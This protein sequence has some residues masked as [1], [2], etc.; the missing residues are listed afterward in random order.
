MYVCICRA[1]TEEDIRATL[2]DGA[3]SMRELRQRLG[4]C[5][6]CCKCAPHVRKLLVEHRKLQ[7]PSMNLIAV[8]PA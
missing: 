6:G 1:V 3:C 2:D 8:E 7:A 5:C 4:V